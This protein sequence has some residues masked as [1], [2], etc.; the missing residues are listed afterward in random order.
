[1]GKLKFVSF[2]QALLPHCYNRNRKYSKSNL[3]CNAIKNPQQTYLTCLEFHVIFFSF[4]RHV[5][6]SQ[7]LQYM[8][9]NN[10]TLK[11]NSSLG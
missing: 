3:N 7:E 2:F 5:S 4:E 8:D 6:F 1:M 10:T 11:R 9:G